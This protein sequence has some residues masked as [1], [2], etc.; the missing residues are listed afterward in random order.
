MP[1]IGT[2][3]STL[4]VLCLVL[5]AAEATALLAKVEG[6][7]SAGK[8]E[9]SSTFLKNRDTGTAV[10]M[11]TKDRKVHDDNDEPMPSPTILVGGWLNL[12]F[13]L[14]AFAYAELKPHIPRVDGM[15]WWAW[16]VIFLMLMVVG[17]R[18][19]DRTV[20]ADKG[21][22]TGDQDVDVLDPDDW[23]K[24]ADS[25]GLDLYTCIALSCGRYKWGI[26]TFKLIPQLVGATIMQLL[27]GVLLL[28]AR[29]P[30][31]FN[32]K[33][34]E[35]YPMRSDIAF[36]LAGSL[37]Y[38]YAAHWLFHETC[39]ACR[40]DLLNFFFHRNISWFYEIPLLIGEFMN[41]FVGIVLQLILF[42]IF[43]KSRNAED[44]TMNCLAVQFLLQIDNELVS[45]AIEDEA[46]QNLKYAVI[47]WT[48]AS[49]KEDHH[50]DLRHHL[51]VAVMMSVYFLRVVFMVM[52][53]GLSFVFFF[54]KNPYLC[55][56]LRSWEP[57][58]WCLGL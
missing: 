38:A 37:L 44:L 22:G 34:L 28:L 42:V 31:G 2:S 54:A 41:I 18:Y 48:N 57:Y 32:E 24:K 52:A 35:L 8:L 29:F 26:Q 9:V 36:R 7:R 1:T 4:K 33:T 6:H 56:L 21:E 40:R 25:G 15:V 50:Y 14:A 51:Q 13:A 49:M 16:A 47:E 53:V 17:K 30:E 12:P 46:I 3:C 5:V 11:A 20:G 45:E 10:A 23:K 55:D 58:P 43:V 19:F 27:V 39:D